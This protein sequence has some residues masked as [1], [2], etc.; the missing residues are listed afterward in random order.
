MQ[1]GVILDAEDIKKIVAEDFGVDASKVIKAQYS[2][3]VTTDKEM[4]S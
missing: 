3:I 1:N 4:K 2:Y